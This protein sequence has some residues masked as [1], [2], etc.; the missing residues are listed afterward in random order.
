MEQ[1]DICLNVDE[2][3][4]LCR[5]PTDQIKWE[6]WHT[7]GAHSCFLCVWM[8]DFWFIKRMDYFLSTANIGIFMGSLC[9]HWQGLLEYLLKFDSVTSRS[10]LDH[11]SPQLT[12]N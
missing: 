11:L 2:N 12:W 4:P 6:R 3:R 1:I 9:K 7:P 10:Q 5:I 8:V